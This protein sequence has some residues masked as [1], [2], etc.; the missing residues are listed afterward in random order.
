MEAELKE[1]YKTRAGEYEDIYAKPER[2]KDIQA[3]SLFLKNN[4]IQKDVLEIACGTG[5]W[6][7][8]YCTDAAS[9]L[10]IDYN[11]EVL[12]VARGKELQ[13]CNVEF[14]VDDAFRLSKV[15]E[16]ANACYAGFWLSHIKK[17]DVN[18]FLR[19]LHVNLEPGSLVIFADNLYV[20]GNSTPISSQDSDGNTY[21]VRTLKDG[22]QHEILKNFITEEEFHSMVSEVS[23]TVHYRKMEYFWYG[24]YEV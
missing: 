12:Q 3:L 13:N 20:E 10:G 16:K 4:F 8:K 22:S 15:T 19:M 1:Y 11:Q 23:K 24:W 7:Q 9:V 5:F 18:A 14:I 21:Q 17:S 2:Q 6:T